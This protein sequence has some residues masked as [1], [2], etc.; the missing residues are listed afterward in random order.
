MR[1]LAVLLAVL[2]GVV[3]VGGGTAAADTVE[4]SEAQGTTFPTKAFVL[5]L[6]QR[7][8]IGARDVI[9]RENGDAATLFISCTPFAVGSIPTVPST[10]RDELVTLTFAVPCSWTGT[11]FAAVLFTV[12]AWA[13]PVA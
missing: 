7:R 5:T 3:I 9:L 6:P 11:G 1:R 4:L 13:S 8:V 12:T 2:G 10:F